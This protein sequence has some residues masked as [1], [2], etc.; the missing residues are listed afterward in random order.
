MFL[1]PCGVLVYKTLQVY[2]TLPPNVGNQIGMYMTPVFNFYRPKSVRYHSA[3]LSVVH[4][5]CSPSQLLCM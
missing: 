5:I 3:V 4:E 2:V 1:E